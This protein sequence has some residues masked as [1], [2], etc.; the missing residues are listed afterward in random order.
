MVEASNLSYVGDAV[1]FG[2]QE[3]I[4]CSIGTAVGG[5]TPYILRLVMD[6]DPVTPA[7][8]I[9]TPWGRIALGTGL[10]AWLLGLQSLIQDRKADDWNDNGGA[11]M[12]GYGTTAA[13]GILLPWA[14][15][16]IGGK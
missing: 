5:V 12:F 2:D 4:W 8:M 6:S 7:E 16:K 3:L 10:I 1:S 15:N 9:D 11:V 14:V 13:L